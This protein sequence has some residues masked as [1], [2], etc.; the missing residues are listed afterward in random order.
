M[1]DRPQT[2]HTLRR[3]A[4]RYIPD[5]GIRAKYFPLAFLD[6]PY[7]S[8]AEYYADIKRQV[9]DELE[10]A[11]FNFQYDSDFAKQNKHMNLKLDYL[12]DMMTNNKWIRLGGKRID[13][14][15]EH[16]NDVK[17]SYSIFQVMDAKDGVVLKTRTIGRENVE[18][19]M[20]ILQ[21]VIR[22][23]FNDDLPAIQASAP[24]DQQN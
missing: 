19:F 12:G 4:R 6:A 5:Q 17:A 14:N 3:P 2:R 15:R 13:L 23:F 8:L 22:A 18:K 21:S 11:S 24:V 10:R 20:D 7:Q 9:E 1:V 16:D